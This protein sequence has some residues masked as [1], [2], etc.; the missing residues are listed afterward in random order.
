MKNKF[1]IPIYIN[2]DQIEGNYIDHYEYEYY[3]YS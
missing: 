3:R 1:N 2:I